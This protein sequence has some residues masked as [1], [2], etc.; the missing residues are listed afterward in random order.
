MS[1]RGWRPADGGIWLALVVGACACAAT[2]PALPPIAAPRNVPSPAPRPVT[3]RPADDAVPARVP[4]DADFR[5]KRPP[6]A[7][8]RSFA[9][10]KVS[11]FR[12]RNGLRV[13]LAESHRL[14]L[15]GI[16]LVVKT[17]SAA[18]GKGQAGLA[19]LVADLLDEGTTTR[20]AL[21]IADDIAQLGASLGTS[22]GWDASSVSVS[23]LSENIDRALAVWADV[24]LR[25][26]FDDGEL[27]RVRDN[28][29]TALRRRKDSPPMIAG[30]TFARVLFGEEHPYGWPSS[31]TEQTVKDLTAAAIRRFWET[32]YRPNNAVVV[33]AGDIT[34]PE[35]RAKMETLL[36]AWKPRPVPQVRVP[37]ARP[38]AKTRVFL[39]DK[40]G[41]PQSSIRVGLVG[42]ERKNP[43]YH[44]ALVMNHILGG[45]F[46]RLG[47]NLRE[48]KGWTYGVGSF[49][50]ARRAPGPWTAGGEF[51]AAHTAESVKE[52]LKE[53]NLLRDE[54]VSDKELEETKDE[55]VKAFP[56][57]FATVNQV[58]GQM[59]ALAVYDLPDND[60]ETF[61]SKIA[62]VSKKDVR[63]MAG[64]YLDPAR[65]AIVVVGD[66]KSHEAALRKIAEVELRDVDGSRVATG[67]LSSVAQ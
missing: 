22:A 28:L 29:L 3:A 23:G 11:R 44:K 65:F 14:P 47:L 7:A 42:M 38:Q 49:F 27:A 39:V 4:P 41:A 33:A 48:A 53:V 15:V 18:N 52:I 26:A 46:K 34:L 8:P 19:D 32:Y 45:S 10:P 43:D 13:I 35:L 63:R 59:V 51:V 62:A 2:A 55:I 64:K 25:P 57:R 12:L 37:V 17:G 50:E 61:T 66:Q 58:A 67:T 16:E 20:S 1:G 31:G 40:A 56:A 21:Q 36:G 9:V 24:V 54:E 6:A 60:L 5:A 30:L